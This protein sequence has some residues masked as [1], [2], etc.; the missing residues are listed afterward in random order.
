MSTWGNP[1]RQHTPQLDELRAGFHEQGRSTFAE[2]RSREA[3]SVRKAALIASPLPFLIGLVVI[4][5]RIGPAGVGVWIAPCVLAMLMCLPAWMLAKRGRT[6]WQMAAIAA[7]AVL[8]E[9]GDLIATHVT[10]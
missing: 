2:Q 8:A 7:G 10:H 6:R 9:A 4:V 1:H 3:R 5:A